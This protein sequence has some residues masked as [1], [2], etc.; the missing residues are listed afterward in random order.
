MVKWYLA[1]YRNGAFVSDLGIIKPDGD[2][3]DYVYKL[4]NGIQSTKSPVKSDW[5][6]I[7]ITNTDNKVEE[8]DGS[9]WN[10]PDEDLTGLV[11][12]STYWVY[13]KPYSYKIVTNDQ[14]YYLKSFSNGTGK[15]INDS[16]VT[17]NATTITAVTIGPSVTTIGNGAFAGC[18]SLTSLNI[19]DSVTSIGIY[20]FFEC[21][22]LASLTIPDNVT[23]IGNGAFSG[24]TS[25]ASLRIGNSVTEIGSLAFGGCTSLFTLN[26][27]DSVEIIGNS[28]FAD[29]SSLASLIIGNSVEIIGNGAFRRCTG[30]E[31]LNIPD[32]VREIN[33]FAFGGCISLT[34]LNIPDSVEIIGNSAFADCSSLASV[35]IGNSVIGIDDGAFFD[36]NSNNDDEA[37]ITISQNTVRSLMDDNTLPYTYT[38]GNKYTGETFFSDPT[39]VTLNVI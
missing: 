15:D 25:L 14:T 39:N 35:T 6:R 21:S 24:C 12:N 32:S 30:L 17:I 16:D 36:I 38:S 19:P 37:I 3:G 20:A 5:L 7:S 34:S 29:C 23:K 11:N 1:T 4:K 26:I 33:S 18:S 28:A 27:P 22:S 2:Y 10:D 31:S 9:N 8:W 13:G